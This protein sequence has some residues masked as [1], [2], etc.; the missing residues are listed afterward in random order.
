VFLITS[1]TKSAKRID[2]AALVCSV[3]NSF[4]ISVLFEQSKGDIQLW[5]GICLF[6]SSDKYM[7]PLALHELSTRKG[8][9][10]QWKEVST[11]P[12]E[13]LQALGVKKMAELLD[14]PVEC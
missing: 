11:A 10:E 13:D 5:T 9:L 14:N 3:L 12:D 2:E 4:V 6:Y 1:A 7:K 8:S